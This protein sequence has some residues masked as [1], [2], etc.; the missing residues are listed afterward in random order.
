LLPVVFFSPPVLLRSLVP[1]LDFSSLF[2]LDFAGGVSLLFG[3]EGLVFGMMVP[4]KDTRD[5]GLNSL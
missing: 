5:A 3:E 2:L 4:G 1:L